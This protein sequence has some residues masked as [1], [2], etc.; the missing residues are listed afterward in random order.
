MRCVKG[1]ILK[2]LQLSQS[3][4]K[5]VNRGTNSVLDARWAALPKCQVVDG[6]EADEK[7]YE[8][9]EVIFACVFMVYG[10]RQFKD[11]QNQVSQ[12]I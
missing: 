7:Q 1:L 3:L 10:K 2:S 11:C 5:H 9:Q 4:R 6:A 8:S 12:P